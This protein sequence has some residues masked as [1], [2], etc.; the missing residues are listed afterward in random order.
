MERSPLP[1][2]LFL[3][4]YVETPSGQAPISMSMRDNH[5]I[6]YLKKTLLAIESKNIPKSL[7]SKI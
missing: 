2:M 7:C 6:Q 1:A 3:S 5:I 4:E